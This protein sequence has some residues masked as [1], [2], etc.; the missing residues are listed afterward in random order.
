MMDTPVQGLLNWLAPDPNADYGQLLPF[1]RDRTTGEK[2]FAMP[3]A[4]R[5]G[6]LGTADLMGA[7]ETG[8]LT[9][10]AIQT[11]MSGMMMGGGLLA[12]RGALAVGGARGLLDDTVPTASRVMSPETRSQYKALNTPDNDNLG[13][14]QWQNIID[15]AQSRRDDPAFKDIVDK[16]LYQN[17]MNEQWRRSLAKPTL[18]P[19]EY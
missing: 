19:R 6:L 17:E 5:S 13:R 18:L 2:R 15:W 12:P 10:E 4:V 7:T 14:Q 3:G 11:L 1:A 9:P 8:S 16:V